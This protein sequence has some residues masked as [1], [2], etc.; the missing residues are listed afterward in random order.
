[1]FIV[2]L[3]TIG[4]WNQ[5]TYP[6]VDEHIKKIWYICTTECYSTI[7]KGMKSVGH[8]GSP[9]IPATWEIEIEFKL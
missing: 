6:S 8:S 1:M 2:A 7:K 5:P 4:I 3:Y 9:V